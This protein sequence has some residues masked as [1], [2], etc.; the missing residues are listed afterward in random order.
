LWAVVEAA[1]PLGNLLLLDGD[2]VD[3]DAVEL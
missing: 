3:G 1:R 2:D